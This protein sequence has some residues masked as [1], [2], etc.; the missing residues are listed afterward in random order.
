MML[1]V[2][3]FRVSGA[4]T[5]G[6]IECLFGLRNILSFEEYKAQSPE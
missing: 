2:N 6:K 5:Q 1:G 4:N 3:E